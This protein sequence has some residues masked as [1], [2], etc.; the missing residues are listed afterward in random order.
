MFIDRGKAERKTIDRLRKKHEESYE[1]DGH[2]SDGRT[3]LESSYYESP[4]RKKSEEFQSQFVLF[5]FL[6]QD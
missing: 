2:D 3:S 1:D 4:R 6:F 5:S